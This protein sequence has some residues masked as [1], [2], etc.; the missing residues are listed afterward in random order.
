MSSKPSPGDSFTSDLK[1]LLRHPAFVVAC[2]VLLLLPYFISSFA[3]Q[4][5][6]TEPHNKTIEAAAKIIPS[7]VSQSV[8]TGLNERR[9][10]LREAAA[11]PLLKTALSSG[12]ADM[13]A[14]HKRIAA[15]LPN[16]S[17][18][19]LI[20]KSQGFKDQSNFV[21][22]ALVDAALRG[23][24]P[25]ITTMK[26]N[27][28]F[29]LMAEPVFGLE[30]V[31]VGSVIVEPVIAEP[32]INEHEPEKR[33]TNKNTIGA[34]LIEVPL[35]AL[36]SLF[37]GA[38]P[39]L[40]RLELV[41]KIVGIGRQTLVGTGATG[42]GNEA[43]TPVAAVPGWLVCFT[44]SQKLIDQ[45]QPDLTLWRSLRA[46]LWA[47]ALLSIALAGKILSRRLKQKASSSGSSQV[48]VKTGGGTRFKSQYLLK[49]EAETLAQNDSGEELEEGNCAEQAKTEQTDAG[50]LS[51][52]LNDE[53][54]DLS[55]SDGDGL[56]EPKPAS[57]PSWPA[58]VFRD[59]DIR[60]LAEQE[61]DEDFASALGQTL[62]TRTL[63]K[64]ESTIIVGRDGRLSSPALAE[65]LVGGLLM[66]GCNVIDLGQVPTPA[67]NFA[68]QVSTVTNNAVIVTASHNPGTFNG[69]KLVS[70]GTALHGTDIQTLRDDM[71][72]KHWRS[73]EGTRA[74]ESI[75]EAYIEAICQDIETLAPLSVVVDCGNGVAGTLAPQL[76]QKLG[77]EC[78]PLYCDVNGAFPNHP[79]DP[80]QKDNLNDLI[81]VVKQAKADVGLAFDGDGDR[82]VA[83][84]ASGRIVWPDELM[85][86]FARDII[87]RHP[88]TD[89]VF[90]VKSTR[91]L[92]SL[93]SDYGGRPVMWK[94]GHAHIRE[95]VAE[96][97]A[98]L[99]GEFSGHLFFSDRW[100][101][102]D[103]GL[104]AAARLLEVLSL[105]EQSLDSLISTF[106]P[107][108]STA[109]IRLPVDD[110]DKF[111]LM[112]KI[113]AAASFENANI[114]TL[115][116][117]RVDF[118]ESWGLIRAS[119]TEA[120]LTLR[121]EANDSAQLKAVQNQFKSL[122]GSV[123][124]E[125]EQALDGA[126][127]SAA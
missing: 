10:A 41:Q 7:G 20:R 94:T 54:F 6:V 48:T 9:Q 107:T 124:L 78:I 125:L 45:H 32:V 90:D 15:L 86:I 62:G 39:S 63:D 23:E 2:A 109:E 84:T 56:A 64:G 76:M 100:H 110:A 97:Q 24:S 70:S 75:G 89:I 126:L 73:G 47:A 22:K 29:I 50:N 82:L 4:K 60:G 44:P 28:W 95:K 8:T 40:G 79:P 105:R 77:C 46:G 14:V 111:P 37:N 96:L 18:I 3:Q 74:H 106:E 11:N 66:T 119:N 5:L 120:A 80:T 36:G 55:A 104:Y 115:D 92:S 19:D 116:G 69:F 57:E 21:T 108:V 99:G 61:I 34:I 101:G 65:A 42:V 26:R 81:Q 30:P 49:R 103:D 38:D 121:F 33:E 1:A 122:L 51:D 53:V 93:I 98:P 87:N 118:E 88:G 16:A 102:F 52:N 83:V 114:N 113:I 13:A 71:L 59:Y 58:H 117:M 27:G 31:N 85:M 67:V 12:S 43:K 68:S 72:A 17:T 25:P 127:S 123:N 35:T 112:E 91:R